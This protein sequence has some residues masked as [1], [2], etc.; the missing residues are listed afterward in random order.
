MDTYNPADLANKI[1]DAVQKEYKDLTRLNVMVLGKTG[2]GKSTLINNMFSEKLAET[3]VGK[4][5]TNKIRKIEKPG[6]PLAIYDTPG[7]ELSGENSVDSLLSEVVSQIKS[8]IKSGDINQTI[9]CI[10]YCVS[11]PSHRIEETEIEFLKNFFSKTDGLDIP[12]IIVLT[13]SY[14][15]KDAKE[16][17]TEIEKEHLPIVNIVPVLAEDYEID[18]EYTAKAFGLDKLSNVMNNSI[19]DAVRKTFIAVQIANIELKKNKAHAVVTAAASAAAA[20]GAVPIPFSDAALLVPEQVTMLAGITGVFG[21]PVEK[22]TLIAVLTGTIGTV[23]TTVLEKSV[24]SGLMKLIP[25]VGSAVGG[26]I[27][28]ATAAA[29]TAALGETYIIILVKVAQGEMTLDE[30]ASAKGKEDIKNIFRNQ[31]TLRRDDLGNVTN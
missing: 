25:G 31:L 2:V 1:M 4:P 16:L 6:F 5:I 26:A 27:S 11:T 13:Q 21:I 9:H 28:G 14:S 10:W 24:V 7:L 8:G 18:E 12:V 29:L 19:P 15:K 30:V 20:T 22:A 23:G 3:G 17:M